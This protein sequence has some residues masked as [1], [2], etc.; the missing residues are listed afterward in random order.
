MADYR[1]QQTGEV[2]QERL[3]MIPTNA[4]NITT[5]SEN[6][7]DK[8]PGKGLSEADFT[9]EEKNKL[10]NLPANPAPQATTYTKDEVNNLIRDFITASVNN[11]VNYYL[12]GETYT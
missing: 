4:E 10:N 11:L 3:D 5:L 7:V 9:S 2:I 12:K 8:V 1:L 6:K